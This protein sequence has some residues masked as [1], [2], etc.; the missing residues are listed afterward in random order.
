M[1]YIDGFVL[2]VPVANKQ[3]YI[4]HATAALP[5]F[6]EFGATRMVECWADDVPDG[7]VTD[8]RRAVKATADEAVVF[9]WME[10]PDKATRD[11]AMEKIM[12][13]P[14]MEEMGEMPFDGARMI[15]AGFDPILV[16]GPGGGS[17]YVD[18]FIAPVPAGNRATYLAHAEKAAAVFQDCGATRIV[19]T[20]AEGLPAGKV[21]DFNMAVNAADGEAIVFSFVEWPSKEARQTGWEKVMADDRMKPDGSDMPFDG[22]R[23]IYGGF[24]PILDA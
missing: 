15:F 7:K 6:K 21:T 14:R 5:I 20:W 18:G 22:K 3:A 24:S 4:D 13:D 9:S 23:M 2:A 17:G 8:F 19:E 12:A 1:A 10:Y 16:A 11:A